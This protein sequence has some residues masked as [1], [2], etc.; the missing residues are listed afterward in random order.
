MIFSVVMITFIYLVIYLFFRLAI[1][2]IDIKGKLKMAIEVLVGLCVCV[3]V[4]VRTC[5]Y[6]TRY[7]GMYV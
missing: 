7:V 1:S 2:W 6:V 3:R 5:I 4:R